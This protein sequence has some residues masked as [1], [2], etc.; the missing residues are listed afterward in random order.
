MTTNRMSQSPRLHRALAA[1]LALSLCACAHVPASSPSTRGTSTMTTTESTAPEPQPDTKAIQSKLTA[2]QVLLRLL[3]AIRGSDSIDDFTPDYLSKNFG[4]DFITY[5]R[6]HAVGEQLTKDWWYGLDKD[7]KAPLGALFTLSF[8][9]NINNSYPD[10]TEIC[11]VDFEKFAS[12]LE[13]MGFSRSKN[14]VEHGRYVGD[15]FSKPKMQ[16]EIIARSE[17]MKLPPGEIGH[18]CIESIFVR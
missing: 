10:M 7:D 16:I 6:G 17:K 15:S 8:R 18:G 1:S 12:E 14:Y 9:P 13:V 2:E 3:Q 5:E 4:I 11:Q